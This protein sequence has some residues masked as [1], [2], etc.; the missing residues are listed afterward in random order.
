M[1]P[2]ARVHE[3]VVTCRVASAQTRDKVNAYL[4]AYEDALAV[5]GEISLLDALLSGHYTVLNERRRLAHKYAWAVPN[6][7]A[8]DAIVARSPIVELG[9]GT[10][11]W[12]A[13]LQERGC[14]VLAFDPIPDSTYTTVHTGNHLLAAAHPDRTLFLCWPT[15]GESWSSDAL[16]L[17][18]GHCVI[19]VGEWRG[20]TGDA[21]LHDMLETWEL[22][23]CIELP[24]WPGVSDALMVFER[25]RDSITYAGVGAP[26]K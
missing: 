7:A 24:C 3:Y 8:L 18:D 13:L 16:R 4:E 9:A 23:Q 26:S 19:Y 20:C 5:S 21:L 15:F 12:A 22:V 1:A 25:T 6:D 11:Y 17:Y 2:L 10:G 14:D